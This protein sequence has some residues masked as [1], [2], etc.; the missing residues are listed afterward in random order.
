[1]RRMARTGEKVKIRT[2][3]KPA[4]IISARQVL[5]ELYI[6]ERVERYIVDLVVATREPAKYK[7]NKLEPLIEFGAS[8]RATINL[9]LAA[10]AHAFLQHRAYVTPEDVRS[11]ASDVLRHRIAPTYEAEAEE[12]TTEEIVTNVLE[13]V[14]VP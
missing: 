4:Q 2:I 8:P 1:M 10:R 3:I 12:I 6:D 5:N 11:I 9:N 13:S 7:L 14:E